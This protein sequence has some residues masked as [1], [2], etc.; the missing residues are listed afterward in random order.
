MYI[1][2]PKSALFTLP[3]QPVCTEKIYGT[4]LVAEHICY[5]KYEVLAS[6]QGILASLCIYTNHLSIHFSCKY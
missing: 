6:M 5:G 2:T 4:Y 3:L 1:N